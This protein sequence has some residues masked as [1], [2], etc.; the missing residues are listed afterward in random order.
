MHRSS[1][2]VLAALL[3][4]APLAAQNLAGYRYALR[5]TSSDGEDVTGTVRLSGDR[6]RIDFPPGSRHDDGYFLLLN[7]GHT[8]VTVHTDRP[9]YER[10]V[11]PTFQRIIGA[12]V[13]ATGHLVT[14]QPED[15]IITTQY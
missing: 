10:V 14:L 12:A 3:P 8:V 13:S 2:L 7:G 4:A 15:V 11:G 5:M 1:L 6:E 9:E